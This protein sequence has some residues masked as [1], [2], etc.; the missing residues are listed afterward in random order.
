MIRA[1]RARGAAGAYTVAPRAALISG[2]PIPRE[3]PDMTSQAGVQPDR[4]ALRDQQAVAR[5]SSTDF[6]RGQEFGG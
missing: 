6:G 2:L 1:A 5:R 4:V 3:R